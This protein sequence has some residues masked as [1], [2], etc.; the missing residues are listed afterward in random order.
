MGFAAAGLDYNGD[1][2]MP[3]LSE[4]RE[5]ALRDTCIFYWWW[6]ARRRYAAGFGDPFRVRHRGPG[7]GAVWSSLTSPGDVDGMRDELVIGA[8]GVVYMSQ[9]QSYDAMVVFK[10]SIRRPW[11]RSLLEPRPLGDGAH[12]VIITGMDWSMLQSETRLRRQRVD[13]RAGRG[14]SKR[15]CGGFGKR[16]GPTER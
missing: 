11:L 7:G 10:R 6:D 5:W 9:G 4:L 2:T 14:G 8:A 16:Y 15:K 12:S 3:S 1:G 13:L